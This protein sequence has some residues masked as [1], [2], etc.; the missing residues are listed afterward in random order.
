[1]LHYF[2]KIPI[3]GM[4]TPVLKLFPYLLGLTCLT[5]GLSA[6]SPA[7]P[8]P[9]LPP[10]AFPT[11]LPA[12]TETP[13]AS[14]APG[15]EE[16]PSLGAGPAFLVVYPT[17][18]GLRALTSASPE[19]LSLTSDGGDTR[20]VLSADGQLVSFQRG[21]E[22]WVVETA[23]GQPRKI[24]GEA[25]AQPLQ[26]AFDPTQQSV[27]LTTATADG[28]PR[29]DLLRADLATGLVQNLLAAGQG[30]EFTFS[31]D[32]QLLALVQPN[33]IL[34]ASASGADLRGV[35]QFSPSP[36]PARAYLPQI[37]WLENNFGFQT[38]IPGQAGQLARW[39]FLPA[40]GGPPAQLAQ[41]PAVSPALSETYLA[42][43][44]SKV[45]YAREQAGQ[46]ELHL[47]DA[48]TAD[49]L[50]LAFPQGQVGPLGWTPDS[51]APLFWLE[52]PGQAWL[53]RGDN[54]QP[55]S[56]AAVATDL[57]WLETET[58]LFRNGTELRLRTASQ[59]SQLLASDVIGPFAALKLR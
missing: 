43:D 51:Q 44:G 7:A 37:V 19:P 33:Q 38:V 12:W 13:A 54:R 39:L 42:P 9:T 30:G 14:A 55:L 15:L 57:V 16:T 6:C 46:L 50:L 18:A 29:F 49:R 56:D 31:P 35:Y 20:P 41:F 4:E 59:P 10:P 52:Q 1:M 24:Y 28:A 48:S 11:A 3:F 40:A 21:V 32:G 58:V 27:L 2:Q 17:S 26:F 5:L 47:L 25:G 36:G 8:N 53:A 45:L 23:G 22:L 34:V